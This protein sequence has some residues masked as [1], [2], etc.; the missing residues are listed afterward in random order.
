M[1]LILSVL[2]LTRRN[3]RLEADVARV[4]KFARF[5]VTESQGDRAYMEDFTFS[6]VED[7]PGA[8]P[9]GFF[10]VSCLAQVGSSC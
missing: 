5:G 4:P 7:A 8:G 10:V 9:R 2:R 1:G 3:R 6:K